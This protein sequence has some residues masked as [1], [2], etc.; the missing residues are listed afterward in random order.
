MLCVFRTTH[1]SRESLRSVKASNVQVPEASFHRPLTRQ[2]LGQFDQP[3]NLIV[4]QRAH[5]QTANSLRALAFFVPWRSL[6]S[7]C[8]KL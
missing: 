5:Y 8:I 1:S 2:Q 3:Q 7:T 4:I 6:C